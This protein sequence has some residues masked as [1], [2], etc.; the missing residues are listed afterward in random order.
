MGCPVLVNVLP[1]GP[2]G[3]PGSSECS[4]DVP[5]D[6]GLAVLAGPKPAVC[7]GTDAGSCFG[8]SSF[9]FLPSVMKLPTT[10]WK[11]EAATYVNRPRN[12]YLHQCLLR[13][14]SR[15]QNP[16][17]HHG[18]SIYSSAYLENRVNRLGLRIPIYTTECLF[19]AVLIQKTR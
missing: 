17:L 15:P 19:T 4:L 10:T 6:G 8:C 9:G 1:L 16:Y 2:K 13:K 14:Q 12:L 5:S 18:I 11:T 3:L 7:G